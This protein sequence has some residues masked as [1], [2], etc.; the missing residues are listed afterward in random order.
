MRR[1]LS[2]ELPN[3]PL[4]RLLVERP[5]WRQAAVVLWQRDPRRGQQVVF[6]S[7]I[8]RRLGVRA[9]MPLSEAL[10]LGGPCS[11]APH[12]G[13]GS[14][15]RPQE[16]HR[17]RPSQIRS[18]GVAPARNQGSREAPLLV[19]EEWDEATDR[20]ALQR[21]A[22]WCEQFCPLTGCDEGPAPAGL[23]LDITG[24]GERWGGEE[25]LARQVREELRRLGYH[26]RVAVA[27][28]IGAAWALARF[29]STELL[30]VPAG[31][32]RA[33][34][35]PLS[36]AC[37]RVR[38]ET[39]ALLHRLGITRVDQLLR[40]PR[41]GLGARLG[42]QVLERLDQALG[43]A[44][45]LLPTQAAEA[46]WS[47]EWRLEHA[48][49]QQDRVAQGILHL[50]SHL[51]Q[52]LAQQERGALRLVCRFESDRLDEPP[53]AGGA[54]GASWL[55]DGR[56]RWEISVNLFRPSA[57]ASH[58]WTLLKTPLEST[59]WPAP[60]LSVQLRASSTARLTRR[61]RTLWVTPEDVDTSHELA[62]LIDRL[63][64]R[65]GAARVCTARLRAGTLPEDA[66]AVL[67]LT[68][69]DASQARMSAGTARRPHAPGQRPLHLLDPPRAIFH[70]ELDAAHRPSRF[71]L[72]P[73]NAQSAGN[74]PPPGVP[75]ER[76][77]GRNESL[78]DLHRTIV[79]ACGPERLETRW[80]QGA[81]VR[82]DYYR[83]DTRE[84]HRYW[85]FQDLDR[86]D[87][88]LHGYFS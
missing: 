68:G 4:Q 82:R 86:R 41:H 27:D 25:K 24:L 2:I 16:G 46:Q 78:A 80:W 88:F 81:T 57:D 62:Q 20:Q 76:S 48:T 42:S 53:A 17:P 5:A 45:E 34:L 23:L 69:P 85:L 15:G 61:Q 84:G 32:T 9:A 73:A 75:A 71:V 21:L 3:W 56:V 26:A 51:G 31:E 19:A 1:I 7:R 28:T 74:V 37:L 83:V 52:Q 13:R 38:P 55:V 18:R 14:P 8:A 54:N 12:S 64:Q 49:D 22:W 65:L 79:Q 77:T 63:S 70:M 30:I 6:C 67:P 39:L 10:A 44:G 72:P 35:A 40:L 11:S 50:A 47:V 33:A 58:W 87:W 59:A 29:S 43:D 66:Y 36:V 60:V